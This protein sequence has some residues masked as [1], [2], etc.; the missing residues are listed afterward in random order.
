MLLAVL[1]LSRPPP[2]VQKRENEFFA[3]D[4]GK[5]LVS[6]HLACKWLWL[7]GLQELSLAASLRRP[8]ENRK[9]GRTKE[10]RI[11]LILVGAGRGGR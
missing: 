6:Q 4:F 5:F 10:E 2:A 11:F 7:M 8:I 9:K 1:G 3:P